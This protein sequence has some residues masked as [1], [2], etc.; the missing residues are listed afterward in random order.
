M[1]RLVSELD[2]TYNQKLAEL[3]KWSSLEYRFV[4][5]W[6]RNPCKWKWEG[7]GTG[8]SQ[9]WG[10][11]PSTDADACIESMRLSAVLGILVGRL[12]ACRGRARAQDPSTPGC[13]RLA[14]CVCVKLA[15]RHTADVLHVVPVFLPRIYLRDRQQTEEVHLSVCSCLWWYYNGV[16]TRSKTQTWRLIDGDAASS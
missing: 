5:G 2:S 9:G 8:W 14:L 10:R 4:W 3:T 15:C 1:I 6:D 12:L 13:I 16:E 7:I 11:P